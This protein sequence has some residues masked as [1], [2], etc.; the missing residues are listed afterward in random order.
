[1]KDLR[2]HAHTREELTALALAGAMAVVPL[3]A[4]EQ[5]GP[6]LPVY[7]DTLIAEHVIMQAAERASAGASLLVCPVLPIGCSDHH[8]AYGGTLSFSSSTYLSMLREIGESLV[9]DGFRRIVFLNAHGGNEPMMT[10]AASDLAVRHPIWT[11]SAS[12]WSIA[13]EALHGENAGEMGLVPG[14][15]GGFETSAVLAL[16]PDWVRTDHIQP[17]HPRREWI[18]AGPSGT[19][20]GRHL[21]LTGYE[22]FTDSAAPA[23]AVHGERYLAAISG[24]VAAWLS[25]VYAAMEKGDRV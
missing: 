18:G 8:L 20:L 10:Q 3:A 25:S 13:R 16:R 19:F 12:Y 17:E 7:T 1:M 14:H 6:H 22:G 21:E 2:F 24:A 9:Q 4:T 11:A 5:H 15:A 23:S